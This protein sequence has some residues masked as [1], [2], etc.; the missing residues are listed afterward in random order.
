MRQRLVCQFYT[1]SVVAPSRRSQIINKINLFSQY[2]LK[3]RENVQSSMK[4]S[5]FRIVDKLLF[6][7]VKRSSI[8]FKK[9]MSRAA[10]IYL[11]LCGMASVRDLQY[12]VW[13]NSSGWI[14]FNTSC[15]AQLNGPVARRNPP[16]SAQ[17]KRNVI[18]CLNKPRE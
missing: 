1:E 2:K 12:W 6:R 14:R 15:A 11:G 4:T 16:V 7:H 3:L 13:I 5:R 8:V 9:K 10:H 18:K 17:R